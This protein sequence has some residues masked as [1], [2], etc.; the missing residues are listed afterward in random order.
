MPFI[1]DYTDYRKFLEDYYTEQKANRRRFS[2][3]KFADKAGFNTKTFLF[4]VIHGEKALSKRSI[5]H[6]AKAMRLKKRETAYFD[7]LVNF[8]DA[9]NSLV[10]EHC[11]NRMRAYMRR[12]PA[13]VL[14]ES[15][16]SYFSKWWHPVIRELVTRRNFKNDFKALAKAT[17]PVLRPK[18]A[19]D[20]VKLLLSLGLIKKGKGGRY[21]KSEGVVATGDPVQFFAGEK[22][23]KDALALSSEALDRVPQKARAISGT[24]MFISKRSVDAVKKEILDFRKRLLS[25][26][27]RDRAPD[28][29]YLGQVSFF[30]IS[31]V[32]KTQW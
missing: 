7:A 5:P 28:R 19:K 16:F 27:A 25:L 1:F 21:R 14:R 26:A 11:F 24:V 20:S 17:L 31:K 13:K 12:G 10:R 15:R 6:V 8:N 23:N 3:Q 4:K 30:P 22:R 32:R 18:Q 29:A 2:Y 9:K